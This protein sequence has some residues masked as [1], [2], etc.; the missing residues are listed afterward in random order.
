MENVIQHFPEAKRVDI[1]GDV[2]GCI[3]ELDLLLHQLGFLL[4]SG[5]IN[6]DYDR[7]LA[8]VGDYVD[9]G[10]SSLNALRRLRGLRGHYTNRK[11]VG[12]LGNHDWKLLRLLQGRNVVQNNG[13]DKTWKELQAWSDP[14]ELTLFQDL[15]E[16]LPL[17]STFDNGKLVISHAGVPRRYL[18]REGM[19]RRQLSKC[20][21]GEVDRDN[22][23]LESGFPNRTYGWCDEYNDDVHCV[24]GHTPV[25]E[26][27]QRENTFN[28]DT[29]CVF[30]GKLTAL[31][32]PE[33][34]TVHV[35]SLAV[36]ANKKGFERR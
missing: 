1:I 14:G 5:E 20:L 31:R 11:I 18:E 10:P 13:L 23:Q 7:V 26:M 8:F 34:E 30:G 22:P 15:L 33:F 25:N 2:H 21:Y 19:K 16:S 4:E 6:P 28:I 3:V 32:Y 29:G 35:D 24:F 12:L 36:Y 9:R 27:A 17:Y